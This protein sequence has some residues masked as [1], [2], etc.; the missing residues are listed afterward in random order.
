[1]F[2]RKAWS[3]IKNKYFTAE[4]ALM[5]FMEDEPDEG[6]DPDID[7]EPEGKFFYTFPPT[8]STLTAG[9]C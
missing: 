6:D 7:L 2:E 8:I 1:M 4:E 5:S 9:A 3:N